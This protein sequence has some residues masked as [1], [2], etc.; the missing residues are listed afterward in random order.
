[1]SVLYIVRGLPGSGKSTLAKKLVF[2]TFHREADMF[3]MVGGEYKFNVANIKPSHQWCFDEIVRLMVC[4]HDCAVSNTFTQKWEYDKYLTAASDLCFDV[5]IIECHGDWDNTHNVP[6]DVLAKMS[7]RW[8]P[9]N[10]LS[11]PL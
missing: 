5:Q 10:P 11:P 2:H 4:G 1:M 9:H 8:E 3:H 7:D 6:E